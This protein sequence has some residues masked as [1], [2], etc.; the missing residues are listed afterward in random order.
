MAYG[1]IQK[2]NENVERDHI[3]FYNRYGLKLAGDLYYSKDLDQLTDKLPALIIG[4]PYGG[5][6]EQ[7]PSVWA[8]EL[9]QRGFVVLTF[10]QVYMGESEGDPRHVSSPDLFAESFS[11]AVDYLGI[12]VPFVDREKIGVIGICGSGGFSLSA[13]S[14]DTRIKAIAT[15]SLYDIT[16][17]RGM[18]N[19]SKD[20]LDELKD[21][22][23]RQRWVDYANDEPEYKPFFP[24]R[25]YSDIDSLPETDPITNEWMRFYA[26]PRGFHA[27]ARGG[28][29]TTSDLSMLQFDALAHIDEIT[30]RPILFIFG[31]HA[32]SH[33]FS[34]RAYALANEPKE[35]YIVDDAEHIDLYDNVEKIPFDKVEDFFKKNL[36]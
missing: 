11:A 28:F 20:Q 7:G 18:Q 22:L 21:K 12:Q 36:K 10:D 29:T 13:A 3:N 31:D 23:T 1:Y 2:L 26:V 25:P 30:P 8:N 16:D 33:A 35:K 4:A 6:K 32:H 17:I 34:E 14:V 19:L 24:D 27:N 5:T 15:A 9:A